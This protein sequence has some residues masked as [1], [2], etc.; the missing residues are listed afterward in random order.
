MLKSIAGQKRNNRK[1][2]DDRLKDDGRL[3]DGCWLQVALRAISVR[4]NGQ[5]DPIIDVNGWGVM[6]ET[7]RK[8]REGKR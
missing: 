6:E 5:K 7:I 3:I 2:K 8:S 4:C 1:K